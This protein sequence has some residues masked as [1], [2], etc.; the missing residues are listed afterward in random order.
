MALWTDDGAMLSRHVV[1]AEE[2]VVPDHFHLEGT[3]AIRRLQM[4]DEISSDEARQ[5][6]EHLL[7]L[8]VRRVDTLPLVREAWALRHNVT[9]GDG[10]YV[11]LARR[12]DIP[13]VT[14]DVRLTKAPHLGIDIL[15]ATQ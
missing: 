13:L 6:F 11:V 3:T 14:G 10:L 15:T 4:R 12:L 5:A 9:I 8:R 1:A 2:I 7:A